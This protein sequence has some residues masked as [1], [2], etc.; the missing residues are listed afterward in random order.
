MNIDFDLELPD[1]TG[2]DL[3]PPRMTNAQYLEFIEFNQRVIHQN[4]LMD[5]VLANRSHP[6]DIAFS[7]D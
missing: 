5:Q 4:G 1:C 7:L 3:P 6:V 2:V